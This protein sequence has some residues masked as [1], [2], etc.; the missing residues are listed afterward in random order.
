MW[1][2]PKRSLFERGTDPREDVYVHN[3][4]DGWWL[5]VDGYR[6][7]AHTVAAEMRSCTLGER[8]SLIYPLVF[9]YR[10]HLELILKY[11]VLVGRRLRHERDRAPTHHRLETLWGDC[12]AIAREREVDLPRTEC[13]LVDEVITEMA[14]LDPASDLFRYPLTKTET[15]PFPEELRQFA[16]DTLASRL[17]SVSD[18]L[19]SIVR[20][21]D[22]DLDLDREFYGDLYCT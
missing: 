7:A 16:P 17:A 2:T 15:F 22:A 8:N 4:G 21:L 6:L 10:Q 9:L 19:H 12:K 20:I 18:V 11:I 5:Y 3:R 1:K 14:E 13:A